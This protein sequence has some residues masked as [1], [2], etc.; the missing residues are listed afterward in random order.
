MT[1]AAPLEAIDWLT[2]TL[3]THK[4]SHQK[5]IDNS[6]EMLNRDF[7]IFHCV[8]GCNRSH[9]ARSR[10]QNSARSQ[11]HRHERNVEHVEWVLL[12]KPHSWLLRW[13]WLHTPV[14]SASKARQGFTF[15]EER[16]KKY[17]DIYHEKCLPFCL[18]FILWRWR[19]KQSC[20]TVYRIPLQFILIDCR[21]S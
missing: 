4:T 16:R 6:T 9:S 20:N 13:N 18:F 12:K 1:A 3:L 7:F 5:R 17:P 15:Y 11:S 2:L 21:S 10:R 8:G 14:P 19:T